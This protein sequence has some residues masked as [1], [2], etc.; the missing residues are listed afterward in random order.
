MDDNNL[1]K[2][3]NRLYRKDESFRERKK[4]IKIFNKKDE[5]LPT[6]WGPPLKK[7][8]IKEKISQPVFLS[9][10]KIFV[11]AVIFLFLLVLVIFY[12]WNRGVNVIS[13]RNIEIGVKSPVSINGGEI[14]SFDITVENRNTATLELS[15]LVIEFPDGSF[16]QDNKELARERYSLGAIKTGE[17]KQ[18]KLNLAL[19][20]EEDEI[21]NLKVS[22][23]YRMEGSNAIFSK[24]KNYSTKIIRPAI[25]VSLNI[26]KEVNAKQ[27]IEI[28]VEIVSNSESTIKNLALQLEYPPGFQFIKSNPVSENKNNNWKIGDLGPSQQRKIIIYGFIEGQDMEERAFKASAGITGREDIFIPFGSSAQTLVIKKPFLDLTLL[29]NGVSPEDTVIYPGDSVQGKIIWKNNLSFDVRD[30]LVELKLRGSAVN[31]RTIRVNGGYFRTFDKTLVWNVSSTDKLNLI[32]PSETGEA[33]FSFSALESLP[34]GSVGNINFTIGAD[35][36]IKGSG[37]SAE[38]GEIEIKN[39]LSENIKI[40]SFLQLA[41]RVLH[42]SGPFDNQGPMP[43]KVGSETT[44]TI[45]LSIGN[46]SNEFTGVKVKAILPSYVRWT[47]KVFSSTQDISFDE[48]TGEIIWNIGKMEAGTGIS[49]PAKEI[50]FQISFLP[51]V[52]Q[53]GSTP[54]LVFGIGMEGRDSFTGNSLSTTKQNLDIKA[55]GDSG[56]NYSEGVVTE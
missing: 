8:D 49:R 10:K 21:K 12:F 54:V 55:T 31:E 52:D 41:S 11:V 50:S 45:V 19:F 37:S 44:Y 4:D 17:S 25:G 30:A 47:G 42:Y 32:K 1:K 22:L 20:G 15:D 23:E 2:L 53:V 6:D 34:T 38:L 14:F 40:S 18:K 33:S 3:K 39:N 28:G 7:K 9:M 16:N 46:A 35:I 24:D 43:P 29:V 36:E 27:Q 26:P 56:F 48:V 5:I 51:S 13:S